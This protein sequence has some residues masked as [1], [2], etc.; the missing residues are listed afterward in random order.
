MNV[1][2]GI[3]LCRINSGVTFARAETSS[4]AELRT[5]GFVVVLMQSMRTSDRIDVWSICKPVGACQKLASM[6]DFLRG[7]AVPSTYL[8]SLHNGKHVFYSQHLKIAH[9][10]YRMALRVLQVTHDL[11]KTS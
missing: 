10:Y 6:M 7:V 11:E 5:C 9:G 2:T 8:G 3:M 1:K 4:R